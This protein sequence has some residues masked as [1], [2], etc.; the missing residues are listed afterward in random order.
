MSHRHVR[1]KQDQGRSTYEPAERVLIVDDRPAFRATLRAM[2]EELALEVAEAND[3]GEAE[4]LMS[5]RLFQ[6]VLCDWRTPEEDSLSLVKRLIPSQRRRGLDPELIF[7]SA[8][9]DS[10]LALQAVELG[11]IDFIAKPLSSTELH[12]RVRRALSERRSYALLNGYEEHEAPEG[13]SALLG[14]SPVMRGLYDVIRQVSKTQSTTLISGESGTGKELIAQAL[15]ALSPRA[16]GPFIVI[17]CAAIPESLIESELFGHARGAFTDASE[18]RSGLF[19]QAEG[20]TIFLDEVGELPFAVQGKLLRALQA[21]EVRPLGSNETMPINVRVISATHRPLLDDVQAGRFRLDL[22]YRLNVIQIQAPPL[23]ER[24]EDVPLLAKRFLERACARLTRSSLS[25]S[26]EALALLEQYCWPGNVREL[27]NAIE[28][29]AVLAQGDLV[30]AQ[31]LPSTVGAQESPLAQVKLSAIARKDGVLTLNVKRE[32]SI[33]KHTQT[34][35]RLLI[36]RALEQSDWVKSRAAEALDISP[37]TLLYKMKDY[38][39]EG[40]T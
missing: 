22:Y 37:K 33:K 40:R 28:H 19:R 3:A 4:R 10:E 9:A 18:E 32:L 7:M 26:E 16:G 39:I 8:S 29:A 1:D 38:N 27:E 5:G 12:F 35:E 25:F 6:L 23:R 36:L 15:H 24:T 11:A 14:H 31:D 2:L 17:N 20:G 13:L 21:R 34:V 30:E